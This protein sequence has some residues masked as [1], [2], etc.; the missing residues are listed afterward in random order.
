MD[1][2]STTPAY[3]LSNQVKQP[4]HDSNEEKS[5]IDSL[6]KSLQE[7]GGLE[8]TPYKGTTFDNAVESVRFV[9]RNPW[10]E[11]VK[12]VTI[13]TESLSMLDA[14]RARHTLDGHESTENINLYQASMIDQGNERTTK[15]VVK[16][17]GVFVALQTTRGEIATPFRPNPEHEQIAEASL[18][19]QES[20]GE[21]DVFL[22][23]LKARFG[24]CV[25]VQTF[26]DGDGPNYAQAHAFLNDSSWGDFV[27]QQTKRMYQTQSIRATA[28]QQMEQGLVNYNASPQ[29]TVFTIDGVIVAN[30]NKNG[31]HIDQNNLVQEAS[32]R[33][34]ERKQLDIFFSLTTYKE[35]D[36]QTFKEMLESVFNE[37]VEMQE[38]YGNKMPSGVDITEKSRAQ[39]ISRF[40]EISNMT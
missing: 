14:K 13:G 21:Y 5:S 3:R 20:H 8:A 37:G 34:I 6:L 7:G 16:I 32:V 9:Q 33:G 30:E 39:Y 2:R 17:D 11:F 28:L 26:E 19:L 36:S 27:N 18:I 35:T 25:S 24:G 29:K 12:T 10:D 31:I 4:P 23:S 1:I 40:N 22:D 38:F 15:A